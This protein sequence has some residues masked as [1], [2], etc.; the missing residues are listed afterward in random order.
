MDDAQRMRLAA[1]HFIAGRD[2]DARAELR[3]LSRDPKR[4][5]VRYQKPP[6]AVDSPGRRS[7]VNY[8]PP[9][10]FAAWVR[11]GWR[12]SY[13]GQRLVMAHLMELLSLRASD[14]LPFSPGHRF[15]EDFTH[16]AVIRCQPAVDHF[17]SGARTG[18][19]LERGNLVSACA[20]C[21][22]PKS[23]GL[24]PPFVARVFDDWDGGSALFAALAD[25]QDKKFAIVAR[26][27]QIGLEL[28]KEPLTSPIVTS[29]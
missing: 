7:R 18:K 12:C 25:G 21:N 4:K 1:E 29:D 22:E 15:K 9:E 5:V 3:L 20:P 24:A 10:G 17:E 13:C 8:K 28:A 11:G 23:D 19:W 2:E 27:L 14:L 26:N 16:P 6:D